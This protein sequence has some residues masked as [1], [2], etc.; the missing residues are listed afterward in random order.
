MRLEEVDRYFDFFA[1][2][3]SRSKQ[4]VIVAR[5]LEINQC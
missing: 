1:V 3:V 4:D 2:T 5:H